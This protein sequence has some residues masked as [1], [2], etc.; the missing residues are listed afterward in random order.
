MDSAGIV[1]F[2]DWYSWPEPALEN[3]PQ[4]PAVYVFRVKASNFGRLLG[5]SDIVYVG[6]TKKSKKGLTSRLR[7]HA[8]QKDGRHWLRRIPSEVGKMEVAWLKLETH[9]TSELQSPCNLVCRLL[10]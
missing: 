9:H 7:G 2:S 1:G 6:T 4:S 10:L 3:A 5:Q 8:G